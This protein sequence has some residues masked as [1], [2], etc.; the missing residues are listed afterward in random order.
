MYPYYN[1]GK[2]ANQAQPNVCTRHVHIYICIPIITLESLQTKH[3]LTYVHAMFA[4]YSQ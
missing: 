2:F 1:V 4:V 3:S